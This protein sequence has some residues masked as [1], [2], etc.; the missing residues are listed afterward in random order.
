MS[1]RYWLALLSEQLT[2]TPSK[3][4]FTVAMLLPGLA[5][6]FFLFTVL[7]L[8]RVST[9]WES[10]SFEVCH[11]FGNTE[12]GFVDKLGRHHACCVQSWF[13]AGNVRMCLRAV[14]GGVCVGV[15]GFTLRSRYTVIFS[16]WELWHMTLLPA[17]RQCP[18]QNTT[19]IRY[20]HHVLFWLWPTAKN[21]TKNS[22]LSNHL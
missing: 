2:I 21:T 20:L 1:L 9:Y 7:M 22:H 11:H 14:C 3:A 4:L 6:L 10:A 5:W 19:E 15:W 8:T 17:A 13:C 18:H 12:I 16:H